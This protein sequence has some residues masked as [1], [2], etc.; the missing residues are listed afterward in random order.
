[1]KSNFSEV[2]VDVARYTVGLI[3]EVLAEGIGRFSSLSFE[4]LPSGDE[5]ER[6]GRT[7]QFTLELLFTFT[8]KNEFE[9]IAPVLFRELGAMH[10]VERIRLF[11]CGESF[12]RNEK[13]IV[14]GEEIR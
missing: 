13:A 11:E 4:I 8:E 7:F 10:A 9:N 5:L 2:G 1:V 12:V 14:A 3:A 6:C